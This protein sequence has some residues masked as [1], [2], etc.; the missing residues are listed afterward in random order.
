MVFSAQN[1]LLDTKAGR[2]KTKHLHI[3]FI[4]TSHNSEILGYFWY[5]RAHFVTVLQSPWFCINEN[6]FE[7]KLNF[8]DILQI[9][10][11]LGYYFGHKKFEMLTSWLRNLWIKIVGRT[12][13]TWQKN[14]T[15][16]KVWTKKIIN[17]THDVLKMEWIPP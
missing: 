1:L 2:K 9:Y 7:K 16:N 14:Q 3:E 17:G 10:I 8:L 11:R 6:V 5:L 15:I 4:V 12:V 13:L